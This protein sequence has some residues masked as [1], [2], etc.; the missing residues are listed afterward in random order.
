MTPPFRATGAVEEYVVP[1]VVG[2]LRY[3]P[4]QGTPS[5]GLFVITRSDDQETWRHRPSPRDEG[6]H[7]V[8]ERRMAG[9]PGVVADEGWRLELEEGRAAH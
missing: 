9:D 8:R 4:C 5:P 2:R 6:H 3:A 1:G 7:V